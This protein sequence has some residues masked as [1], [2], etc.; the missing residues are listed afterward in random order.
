VIAI[1]QSL[2]DPLS[3]IKAEYLDIHPRR[4]VTRFAIS[5]HIQETGTGCDAKFD[6]AHFRQPRVLASVAL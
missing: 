6:N 1:N 4:S 5:T 3:G 2:W